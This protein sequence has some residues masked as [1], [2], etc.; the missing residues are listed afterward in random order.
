[1]N[2][3]PNSKYDKTKNLPR[4]Y[5][6]ALATSGA[7]CC[8]HPLDLVKVH[9]QTFK[10]KNGMLKQ[11]SIIFSS[12]GGG[13]KGI[14]SIYNGLTASVGRQITYS[15]TRFA[16]YDVMKAKLTLNKRNLT[17]FEKV[18]LA[19][20]GGCI[21]GLFGTPCDLV[22]VRMQADV[23]IHTANRRNYKHVFDGLRQI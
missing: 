18:Y 4:W 19:F 12:N 20:I 7:A 1:M 11:G 5:F 10:T 16:V 23:G 22:N 3:L 21:G 14:A 9:L 2:H 6:G 8:T 17:N 13:I 15:G